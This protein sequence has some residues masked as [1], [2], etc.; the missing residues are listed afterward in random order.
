M[1]QKQSV[2]IIKN[3]PEF[4]L[5]HCAIATI[6]STL[7]CLVQKS[8]FSFSGFI[9]S[10]LKIPYH[11]Y[12]IALGIATFITMI[13]LYLN[14]KLIYVK[15]HYW[16]VGIQILFCL[17]LLLI[18]FFGYNY[19]M[20][21][22]G[23]SCVFLSYSLN[24]QAINIIV[25]TLVSGD[26][27]EKR[28]H[29]YLTLYNSQW[30][31]ATFLFI[32]VGYIFQYI[33]IKFFLLICF[34][35]S[36]ILCVINWYTMPKISI[37]QYELL[38]STENSVANKS[39]YMLKLQKLCQNT[40]YIL[41]AVGMGTFFINWGLFYTTFGFWLQTLYDLSSSKLGLLATLMEGFGNTISL[42]ALALCERY[43]STQFLVLIFGFFELIALLL[44]VLIYYIGGLSYLLLNQYFIYFITFLW[45]IGN[46]GFIVGSII[47][48]VAIPLPYQQPIASALFSVNSAITSSISSG[49]S[50]EIYSKY[51]MGFIGLISF[52]LVI[53]AL[54]LAFILWIIM[55]NEK[56]NKKNV[57]LSVPLNESKNKINNYNSINN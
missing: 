57:D 28:R 3:K 39:R 5:Y 17:G 31:I 25:A 53:I 35:I 38:Y 52:I 45:F 49:I 23:A 43:F 2:I 27:N 11:Y 26:E 18:Y 55:R 46:E 42:V 50:G 29:Y 15:T 9:S 56:E 32:E 14:N 22:I 34:G 10:D 41:L 6:T 36:L 33:S 1:T 13:T 44:L 30:T 40:K 4:K 54:V 20:F 19:I 21:T 8:F 7:D 48:N 16:I 37:H 24:W 51:G 12:T 47:L